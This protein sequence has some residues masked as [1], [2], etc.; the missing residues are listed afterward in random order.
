MSNKKDKIIIGL[1]VVVVILFIT[2]T[3]MILNL[4]NSGTL[5]GTGGTKATSV[6]VSDDTTKVVNKVKESVVTVTIYQGDDP[7]STGSGSIIDYDGGKVK[8]VTNNHVVSAGRGSKIEILYANGKK[9]EAKVLGKDPISDLALLE[10]K[11]DFKAV[12]I[13]IGDSN[14]LQ[15]GETVI[16]I[17][18]P[19]DAS[20]NNTVT[21]GIISG[22]NRTI[23]TD[24]NNDGIADYAMKV[25]QTDTTINPGNSG[26]PLINMA[27]QLIGINT[28][29]ISMEGFEGMGFSIPS[30][31]AVSILKDLEKNGKISRPTLGI[32][33]QAI[34][35]IPEYALDRF[36]IPAD[37]KE[38]IYVVDVVRGSSAA[39]SGIKPNDIIIG[40]D[41]KELTSTTTFTSKLY[42][43]KKGDKMKLSVLRDGS[44]KDIEVELR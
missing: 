29:K 20:F 16:A 44:T 43:S 12:P 35:T 33:F 3:L 10:A 41:G 34:S 26:G 24:T 32:S 39:R 37:L 36:N 21:R 38:G 42:S 23:E 22:L 11:V 15:S 9:S 40:V 17:G 18:S 8:I 28:S 19:L 25:I 6:S 1:L 13:E 4:K 14:A 30:S 2:N 7:I 27:G 31:E 5:N